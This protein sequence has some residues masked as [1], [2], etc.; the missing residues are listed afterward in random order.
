[1]SVQSLK[2]L[3]GLQSHVK[4]NFIIIHVGVTEKQCFIEEKKSQQPHKCKIQ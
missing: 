3:T 1:M 4:L 2:I